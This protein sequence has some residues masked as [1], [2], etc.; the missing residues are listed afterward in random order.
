M[1]RACSPYLPCGAEKGEYEVNRFLE[2]NMEDLFFELKSKHNNK[3]YQCAALWNEQCGFWCGYVGIDEDNGFYGLDYDDS[4][5]MNLE[6]H[7]G[8]TFSGGLPSSAERNPELQTDLDM[9][10]WFFGFDCGHY[11]DKT[12]L[13][14]R[15][16]ERNLDFVKENCQKLL[17]ELTSSA[18]IYLRFKN[19]RLISTEEQNKLLALATI[20]DE[21]AVKYL[22][23]LKIK[24]QQNTNLN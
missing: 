17:D 8:V 1:P 9:N 22:N 11:N 2:V 24:Q 10:L 5:N 12:K 23:E 14:P 4:D 18:E 16:V 20:G 6:V 7:G 19:N 13:N 21:Y 15:G 3:T